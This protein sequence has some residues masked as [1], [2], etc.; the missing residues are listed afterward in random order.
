MLGLSTGLIYEGFTDDNKGW[1]KGVY[2]DDQTGNSGIRKTIFT[3][4]TRSSDDYFTL[5]YKI[6]LY[7]DGADLW[8]GT[9]PTRTF[10]SF[11]G[12]NPIGFNDLTKD[13][14]HTLTT[15]PSSEVATF[16]NFPDVYLA[17]TAGPNPDNEYLNNF[18]DLSWRLSFDAPDAGAIFFIKDIRIKIYN[19]SN[20]LLD[21]YDSN[22]AHSVDGFSELPGMTG[23]IALSFNQSLPEGYV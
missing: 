7:E 17:Q 12:V 10:F 15:Y 11:G 22:F 2:S 20:V 9:D 1:L 5:N 23:T 18:L 16:E 4:H 6:L 13:A 21:S 14:V 19:S 3:T 8:G